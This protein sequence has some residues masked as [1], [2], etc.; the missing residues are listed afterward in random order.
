M[1]ISNIANSPRFRATAIK[2]SSIPTEEEFIKILRSGATLP[3]SRVNEESGNT[4]FHS[5]VKANYTKLLS[6]MYARGIN[7]DDVINVANKE[8][9]SPLDEA[10]SKEMQIILKRLGGKTLKYS[11]ETTNTATM[12]ND[13]KVVAARQYMTTPVIEKVEKQVSDAQPTSYFDAFEEVPVETTPTENKPKPVNEAEMKNENMPKKLDTKGLE[14]FKLLEITEQDIFRLDDLIGLDDVK[15]ELQENIIAP[16]TNP[17]IVSKCK[18]NQIDL[19]NGVLFVGNG[20]ALTT[21]KA[22]SNEAELPVIIIENPQELTQVMIAVENRYK[23]YGLRTAILAQGF[24]RWWGQCA[25]CDNADSNRFRNNIRGIKRKGGLFIATTTDKNFVSSDFVRSGIIDKVLNVSKPNAEDRLKFIQGYFAEREIFSS[26]ANPEN[27]ATI[28]DLTDNLYYVDIKR[29]L[30]ESARTALAKGTTV[31]SKIF[32]EQLD[33]FSRETNRVQITNENKTASYDTPKFQRVPIE[34]GEI[35]NL[36][37]LG[38]M[39]MVKKRLRELYVEPM[40]NIDEMTKVFGHSA[41]PDGAIFY[42]PS[43]NGKTLTARVL[44]RELGLPFYE[45]RLTDFGT[46]YIHE[47]GKAF[48]QM[49]EQLD[50]KFKETGERSVWFLDEFDSIGASRDGYGQGDKELTD[51]LLQEFTNPAR[52]GFILIAATNNLDDVD[53]ALKRRG[54]LGNWIKFS[55]PN[56]E[57]REDAIKKLLLKRDFTKDLA[58][59]EQLIY[60]I[61]TELDGFSMSSIANVLEDANRDFYM[62]KTDYE[63]AVKKALDI[64]IQREMGEFCGKAGLTQHQYSDMDF[65]SLDE[66]GGMREVIQQLR[67]HV[68]DTWDPEIRQALLANKRTPSSG[69]ILEG[70]PGGGKTTVI[71]TLAREMDIP[72]YKMDY[73]QEGNEYV[74]QMPKHIHEIF[75]RL[76]LESKIIKKPVMLFFD[77]AEKF[78]PIFAERHK[79]EE[80]NTYKELMN[81]AAAKGIILA[82]ATNHIDLVNQEITGN[83]RRMGTIIHVGNPNL[84]D[85][86][87]VL[88]KLLTGLPIITEDCTEEDIEDIAM[89]T[90]GFSIGQLT[91]AVDKI[92]VQAVKK[93]ANLTPKKI[94]QEF[95]QNIIPKHII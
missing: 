75:D 53:S 93:K 18:E 9:L 16:L 70:P 7:F 10:Q 89:I 95:R 81:T 60:H 21:I 80:V 13:A 65:K 20:S 8:G 49:A 47:S 61:A 86:K 71:E 90:D 34:E 62:N 23:K 57:E 52:R 44:A 51:A 24:D 56:Q 4:L 6:Y 12:N 72:L 27:M 35:M 83:P 5:I 19:P 33:D 92:I 59:N 43:G 2:D 68:I 48:A 87:E 15:N 32:Q 14:N 17:N 91:D 36:D 41:I 79:M 85:R 46:A 1:Y 77:E 76:A 66:L 64:N 31:D 88:T 58:E 11:T 69:F 84:E 37:E 63:T 3:L 40:K 73:N 22:L 29:I 26:I 42:G 50:R 67:E 78:F 55:N 45:T 30:D 54:R 38:G 25:T 94:V 28:V 74:Y 39:P 82:G